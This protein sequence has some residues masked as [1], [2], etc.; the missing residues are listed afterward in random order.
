MKKKITWLR[1]DSWK[2]PSNSKKLKNNTE[3]K[4]SKGKEIEH[5]EV[6]WN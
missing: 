1:V 6:K 4:Q 2:Q 5:T 3:A